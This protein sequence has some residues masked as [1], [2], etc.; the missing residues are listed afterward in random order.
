MSTTLSI[1]IPAF[2]EADIIEDS[3]SEIVSVVKGLVDSYELIVIDDGSLDTTW[4]I[5]RKYSAK[6]HRIKGIRF[7]RNFGKESAIFAG[8]DR[9]NGDAVVIIDADL[10]HPPAYI[11]QMFE[12]WSR[13]EADIVRAVKSYRGN[14]ALIYKICSKAFYRLMKSLSGLDLENASDFVLIDKK[15][16][17]VLR[18]LPE[19]TP[20]LRGLIAWVGFR[21]TLIW[22]K[23]SPRVG[24]KTKWKRNDLFKYALSNFFSFSSAPLRIINYLAI[25]FFIFASII[26][27][28]SLYKYITHEAVE[29]F[30]TLIVL[31]LLIGS[32]MMTGLGIIGGYI[33]KIHDEAKQRPR[34]L[35]MD[36]LNG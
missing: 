17:S 8:I 5:L 12:I 23:V 29:G 24:G 35:T 15:V 27:S 32:I 14:E 36:E 13:N 1:V 11:Q 19:Q 33:S 3:L 28:I 6:N 30:T 16:I 25:I 34:Y 10:Q 31:L 21:Q 4:D 7:S 26:G 22:F 18:R 2:N 9:A 20:F